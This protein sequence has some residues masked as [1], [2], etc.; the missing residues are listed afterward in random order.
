MNYEDAVEVLSRYIDRPRGKDRER[1]RAALNVLQTPKIRQ[2]DH[3]T[4][5]LQTK[6]SHGAPEDVGYLHVFNDGTRLQESW[7]VAEGE[8]PL[9]KRL[10]KLEQVILTRLSTDERVSKGDFECAHEED[11]KDKMWH[12]FGTS[13]LESIDPT[14]VEGLGDCEKDG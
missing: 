2:L 9:G 4:W 1:A 14:P 7:Y 5:S 11:L 10:A 12:Q 13:V 6:T 8:H 3:G